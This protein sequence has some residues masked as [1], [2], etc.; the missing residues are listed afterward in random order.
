MSC[1]GFVEFYRGNLS[2]TE[3]LTRMRNLTAGGFFHNGMVLTVAEMMFYNKNT[4]IGILLNLKFFI[5]NAGDEQVV[6]ESKIF[7]P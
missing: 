3:V 6:R 2:L 4:N 1:G 7:L 5:N